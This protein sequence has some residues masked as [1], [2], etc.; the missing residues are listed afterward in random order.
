MCRASASLDL[1][2]RHSREIENP[3]I[4]EI[5]NPHIITTF[6]LSRDD[7]DPHST[8]APPGHAS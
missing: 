8:P 4:L 1:V 6:H 2:R 3:H 5:E 7:A